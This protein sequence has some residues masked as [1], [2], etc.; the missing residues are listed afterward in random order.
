M[1]KEQHA[2]FSN[3]YNKRILPAYEKYQAD[4]SLQKNATPWQL[5]LDIVSKIGGLDGKDVAILG[6]YDVACVLAAL[7]ASN[8]LGVGTDYNFKSLTLLTDV[9]E[10]DPNLKFNDKFKVVVDNLNEPATINMM[11]KK[12]DVVIGNPPYQPDRGDND[13]DYPLWLDFVNLGVECLTDEGKLVFITPPKFIGQKRPTSSRSKVDYSVFLDN[14]VDWVKV[15]TQKESA[16]YF[17]GVGSKFAVYAISKGESCTTPVTIGDKV[18]NVDLNNTVP[19]PNNINDLTAKLFQQLSG[20][21]KFVFADDYSCHSQKYK[22]GNWSETLTDVCKVPIVVSHKITRYTDYKQ[23]LFDKPKVLV[24]AVSTINN[25][26]FS[27]NSNFGEDM[28]YLEVNSEEEASNILSILTS[29]LYKFIGDNFRPGRNLDKIARNIF[30]K[31][32]TSK[33]WTDEEIYEHFNLT[34][35]EI[36]LVESINEVGVF[37]A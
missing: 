34:D 17:S 11:G 24:P 19:A 16:K 2:I 23:E 31:L 10:F 35:S 28:K 37:K 15:L 33:S 14:K 3:A 26:R 27:Q 18:F 22:K 30:P 12:F 6:N 25:A 21:E 32:D 7:E 1:N 13:A 20:M 5:V 36:K 4:V 29:K 9:V 8:G